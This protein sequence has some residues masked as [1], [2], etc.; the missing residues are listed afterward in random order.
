M[1]RHRR[2]RRFHHTLSFRPFLLVSPFLA[3][4]HT[5]LFLLLLLLLRLRC[6]IQLR[7]LAWNETRR[8]ASGTMPMHLVSFSLESL[9]LLLPQE[10]C[11]AW[12]WLVGSDGKSGDVNRIPAIEKSTL[13][14]RVLSLRKRDSSPALIAREF[15]SLRVLLGDVTLTR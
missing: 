6:S 11:I 14:S 15:A 7:H 13:S 12:E 1:S 8:G 3:P 4:A 5:A 9:L 10:F 2:V